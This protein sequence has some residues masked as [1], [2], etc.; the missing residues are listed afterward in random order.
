M[1][2]RLFLIITAILLLA[3]SARAQ[4]VPTTIGG[5]SLSTSI[6]NPAPGQQVTITAQSYSAD[7]DSS[8]VTWIVN[9][10][11][12]KSGIG[13]NTLDVTA[14]PL[15]KQLNIAISII[16]S[17][18]STIQDSLTVS[19]GSIDLILETSGYKPPFYPGKLLPVYQNS[20]RVV[21][22]PHLANSSGVE[23]DPATLVYEWKK[24]GEA[25][26]DQSGYGKQSVIVGGDT[27]PRPHD[28]DVTVSTRDGSAQGEGLITVDTTAPNISFYI[29][30]PLYGPLLNRAIKGTLRIGSQKEMDVLAVPWGFDKPL[31]GLGDLSL[32]WSVNGAGQPDLSNKDSIVLRAPDG[33]SGSSDI[34]LDATNK[35][36]FLQEASGGFSVLFS[37]TPGAATSSA[38]F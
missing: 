31:S 29:N 19:S 26:Q 18:G 12:A 16:T 9:G 22:M 30:D 20:V 11:V 10:K 5:L 15:G 37:N 13:A 7:I 14:P 25:L 27:I 21:A 34:E 28:I 33:V 3:S 35:N 8:T 32:S 38:I 1:K 23:Y 4:G 17:A 24:D 6:N 36:Q 2:Q